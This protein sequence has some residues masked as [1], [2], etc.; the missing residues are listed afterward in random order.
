MPARRGV[1]G[2]AA[3]RIADRKP[4]LRVGLHLHSEASSQCKKVHSA[5]S[6]WDDA[7]LTHTLDPTWAKSFS[8]PLPCPRALLQS[9]IDGANNDINAA[10]KAACAS[11]LD[12]WA[13]GYL[14][15]QVVDG[16]RFNQEIFLGEV[17][18]LL[19]AFLVKRN[20]REVSGNFPLSKQQATD[21]VSGTLR[22][23]AQLQ[24]P[25]ESLVADLMQRRICTPSPIQFTSP[26]E[27]SLQMKSATTVNS[28]GSSSGKRSSVN[29]KIQILDVA[30]CL[31]G[32]SHVQKNTGILL[33]KMSNQL[34]ARRLARSA[35]ASN[36][37]AVP[38]PASPDPLSSKVNDSGSTGSGTE[39]SSNFVDE[40]S[41]SISVFDETASDAYSSIDFNAFVAREGGGGHY[42]DDDD[43]VV[44]YSVKEKRAASSSLLSEIHNSTER[45]AAAMADMSAASLAEND[46]SVLQQDDDEDELLVDNS[47]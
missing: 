20:N 44:V 24:L 39:Y 18:L 36:A 7:A 30:K 29:R 6:D 21:R 33:G 40:S 1:I 5:A 25:S 46:D 43:D 35:L 28:G 38:N 12:F 42:A 34:E 22:L 13:G 37:S 3:A 47:I 41:P 16:E 19:S 23:R 8:L 4:G 14:S 2:G 27:T 26:P 32:L 15:I 11:L 10:H 31:D 17:T 9:A 45:L